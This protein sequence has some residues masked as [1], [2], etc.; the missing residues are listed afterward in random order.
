[1]AH[2][3]D[4]GIGKDGLADDD[5]DIDG[6]LRDAPM[7]DPHFLDKSVVLIHQ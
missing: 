3:Q 7:R 2:S 5:T 4:G 6:R 1:M